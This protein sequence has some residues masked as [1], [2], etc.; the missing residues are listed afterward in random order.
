MA[1]ALHPGGNGSQKKRAKNFTMK[2]VFAVAFNGIVQCF[3]TELNF[4]IQLIAT[5]TVVILGFI[6][7]ITQTQWFV[8][9]LCCAM[10]LA[11]ELINT[12]IEKLCDMISKDFHPTIKIVKDTAAGAVLVTAIGSAVAGAVIF[13]PLIIHQIK[14]LI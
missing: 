1:P 3:R 6:F 2:K 4:K 10:V 11:L 7:N 14:I 8:I 9:I 13:V 12:A 5:L